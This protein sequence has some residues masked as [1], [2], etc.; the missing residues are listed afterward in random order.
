MQNSPSDKPTTL[1]MS[2]DKFLF[3]INQSQKNEQSL[4]FKLE[5]SQRL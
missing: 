4:F 3:L 5:K 2:F 1:P